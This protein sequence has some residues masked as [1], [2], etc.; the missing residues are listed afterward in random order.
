MLTFLA[1]FLAVSTASASWLDCSNSAPR[2][3]ALPVAGATR[4]VI[5]GR[6][7]TLKIDGHNGAT[8]VRA[9]G[10]ACSSTREDLPKIVLRASRSGSEIRIEAEMPESMSWGA[11]SL[12]FEVSLPANVPVKVVD[13]SGELTIE[14]TA[15]L[16][17]DDGSG[18][19]TI[20]H[21]HGDLSVHDGSGSMEIEDVTG[22]VRIHDGSGSIDVHRVTGSVIVNDGSGSVDV[23]DVGGDFLVESKGS[24]HVS[25]DRIKGKV[26]VPRR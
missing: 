3:A 16:D 26:D 11:R 13:G 15:A 2:S 18:S 20:R 12:D 6:A 19:L 9:V 24:G 17:V 10:K 14:N 5:V 23:T 4:I 1:A 7:G 21:V 22:N 25:Y 8:E